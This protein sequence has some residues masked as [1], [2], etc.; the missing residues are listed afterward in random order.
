MTL[1]SACR[2]KGQ[3]KEGAPLP[4]MKTMFA[5]ALVSQLGVLM[6]GT[7]CTPTAS[8]TLTE[9]S[10]GESFSIAVGESVS[11][12]EVD[13]SITFSAVTRDSRCPKDVNC[14]V[15]GEAIVIFQASRDGGTADLTFSVPPG[16]SDVQAFEEVSIAITELDPQAESG[17]RIDAASYAAKVTVTVGGAG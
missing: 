15:A 6:A 12:E 8:T 5:L 7:D 10:A 9:H 4:K 13:I 16:G 14:I 2:N 1:S 17:K 3:D 11:L